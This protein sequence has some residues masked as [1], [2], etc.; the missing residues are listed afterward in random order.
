MPEI[1]LLVAFVKMRGFEGCIAAQNDAKRGVSTCVR[2]CNTH[3]VVGRI[4]E[5]VGH[6]LLVRACMR[7]GRVAVWQ[8][9]RPLP[10][11][12]TTFVPH[13]RLLT[14]SLQAAQSHRYVEE[15]TRCSTEMDLLAPQC[16]R[17]SHEKLSYGARSRPADREEPRK[18][19][20]R[21]RHQHHAIV[22]IAKPAPLRTGQ[23]K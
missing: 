7:G 20:V 14:P 2:R 6:H 18:T 21:R 17:S 4:H 22:A 5:Q 3:R 13:V 8:E 12:Y 1:V 11:L 19:V 23:L 15:A 10:C 16:W 9:S